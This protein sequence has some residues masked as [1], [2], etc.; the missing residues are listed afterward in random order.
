M[1]KVLALISGID[2]PRTRVDI[3]STINF[4]FDLYCNNKIGE[5]QL[6]GDLTE[7]C[8]QIISATHPE[9]TEEDI[10]K[11][12]SIVVDDLMKTMRIEG[13]RRLT[14]YRFRTSIPI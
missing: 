14:I 4:L 13:L 11:R 1:Q 2:D 12:V 7:I 10:R 6:R 9:L 3:M 5:D 8:S